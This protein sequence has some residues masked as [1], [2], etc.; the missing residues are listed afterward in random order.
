RMAPRP[1]KFREDG[2]VTVVLVA[3]TLPSV[4]LPPF[5]CRVVK[6]PRSSRPS[7]RILRLASFSSE[8]VWERAGVQKSSWMI[9]PVATTLNQRVYPGWHFF[10]V[11]I[12][13]KV[14]CIF[15]VYRFL[16]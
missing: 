2:A 13:D 6:K 3:F 16:R 10:A 11:L 15:T 8:N 5:S 7:L 1:A 9:R 14:K 12:K 4:I